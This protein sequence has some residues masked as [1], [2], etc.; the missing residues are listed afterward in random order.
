M[1]DSLH[2]ISVDTINGEIDSSNLHL[3]NF[4]YLPPPDSMPFKVLTAEE[5]SFY[6][7]DTITQRFLT[8]AAKKPVL[9]NPQP[10]IRP[11]NDWQVGVLIF[12]FFVI[13]YIRIS[14]KKFFKNLMQGLISRP[15]FRQMMR[16]GFLFS[17]GIFFPMMLVVVLTYAIF[18][19]QLI[20][21]FNPTP[22]INAITPLRLF[23]YL[24]ISV[25]VLLSAKTLLV[26]GSGILFKTNELTDEYLT[27][28]YFFHILTAIALLPIL[29]F[30]VFDETSILTYISILFTALLF[31][32][33]ILRGI[34]I[35]LEMQKYSQY[36]NLLYLCTLEILP[37]FI[38]IKAL[39]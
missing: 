11:Q 28:S 24:F 22:L 12:C 8:A 5:M 14:R 32:Y 18:I 17:T 16:E 25:F 3:L 39:S 4:P 26:R 7:K 19:Y 21:Y 38:I 2:I 36:Q 9:I 31:I 10:I 30:T 37:I 20:A 35:S 23:L 29:L 1:N 27:N 6:K 33:R 15:M 13:S 34:L